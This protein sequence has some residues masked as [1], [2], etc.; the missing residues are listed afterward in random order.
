[1]DSLTENS[2]LKTCVVLSP[3]LKQ[4][5]ENQRKCLSVPSAV[6]N[7][8]NGRYSGIK[9]VRWLFKMAQKETCWQGE[10]FFI[11]SIIFCLLIAKLPQSINTT[12]TLCKMTG[13]L[14][15]RHTCFSTC[16]SCF[17]KDCSGKTR[18]RGSHRWVQMTTFTP[19]SSWAGAGRR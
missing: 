10:T 16:I 3:T 12:S 14:A 13:T 2:L 9:Y 1:M 6:L 19:P 5:S 11:C 18:M 15:R 7:P 4:K 8:C 17:R